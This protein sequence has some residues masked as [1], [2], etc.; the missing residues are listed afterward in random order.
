[1]LEC[2]YSCSDL[3]QTHNLFFSLWLVLI[4]LLETSALKNKCGNESE[5]L[6]LFCLFASVLMA[7]CT[8]ILGPL[9][10]WN[11]CFIFMYICDEYCLATW[12]A[13]T[14]ENQ[15]LSFDL[16]CISALHCLGKWLSLT[17]NSCR[18]ARLTAILW[19]IWSRNTT[20]ANWGNSCIGARPSTHTKF[21]DWWLKT[22]KGLS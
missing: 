10:K 3:K 1:M 6:F 7:I 13:T 14:D 20:F 2:F 5:F 17:R 9:R 18:D 4:R 16:Q 19:R 8:H 12:I 15:L 21:P 11:N 22:Q